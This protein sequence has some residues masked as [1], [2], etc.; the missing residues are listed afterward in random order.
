[1][2][3][4]VHSLDLPADGD[5]ETGGRRLPSLRPLVDRVAAAVTSPLDRAFDQVFQ[6]HLEV[7][8]VDHAEE[9]LSVFGAREK[10]APTSGVGRAGRVA[11]T[12]APAG[13]EGAQKTTRAAR[14]SGAGRMAAWG[15]TATIAASRIVD[16][17]RFG[18]SELQIMAAYLASRVR[19]RAAPGSGGRR[20]G[21]AG[22]LHQAR[23]A[24]RPRPARR[25]LLSAA[26][27]GGCWTPS[28][29]TPRTPAAAAPRSP[30]GRGRAAER[31]CACSTTPR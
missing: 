1:M 23:P 31:S 18:V 30:P 4:N 8:S 13:G 25:K 5:P 16:T 6:R 24:A 19:T 7:R 22:Y 2:T 3:T 29:P 11:P 15:V 14:F 27:A 20:A 12:R 17:S 10:A 28:G 21:R 26:A 9:L